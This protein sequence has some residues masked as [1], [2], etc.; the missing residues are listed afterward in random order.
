MNDTRAGELVTIATFFFD[1][2]AIVAKSLLESAGIECF[3]DDSNIVRME[4]LSPQ[5]FGGMKLRVRAEDEKSAREL[6]RQV[7]GEE[8]A[9]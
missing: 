3:L 5:V 7:E 6:L 8:P 1:R 9:K 2:E 4:S